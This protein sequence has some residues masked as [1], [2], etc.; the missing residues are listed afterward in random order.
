M[1]SVDPLEEGMIHDLGR[2][3][4]DGERFHH[5]TQNGIQFKTHELFISGIFPLVFL[6]P[7]G[8]W[9]PEAVERESTHKGRLT[10]V[11]GVCFL[12]KEKG[13]VSVAPLECRTPEGSDNLVLLLLAMTPTSSR[14]HRMEE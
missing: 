3:Q 9:V 6:N 8:P 10:T 12:K 11:Y 1:C 13:V 14:C 2:I 5:A 7:C 4:L